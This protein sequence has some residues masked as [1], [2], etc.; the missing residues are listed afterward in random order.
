[1]NVDE[2]CRNWKWSLSNWL[3]WNRK[4]R[5]FERL[6]RNFQRYS[7]IKLQ[8]QFHDSSR[9]HHRR[10]DAIKHRWSLN[11]INSPLEWHKNTQERK[12][13]RKASA[14]SN[15]LE[16][17]I[18]RSNADAFFERRRKASCLWHTQQTTLAKFIANVVFRSLRRY[19]FYTFF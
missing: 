9:W 17:S 15:P 12:N 5:K 2:C 8:Q 19:K 14:K 13:V 16:N 7:M 4:L 6:G 10:C 11:H 18:M 3:T 1:M